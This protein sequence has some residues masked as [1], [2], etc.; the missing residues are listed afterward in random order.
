VRVQLG[1]SHDGIGQ[2]AAGWLAGLGAAGVEAVPVA[3][4]VAPEAAAVMR[5]V[6][7][8]LQPGRD[9]PSTPDVVLPL[10]DLAPPADLAGWR[11]ARDEVEVAVARWLDDR[12]RLARFGESVRPRFAIDFGDA[13]RPVTFLNHGSFGATPRAVLEAQRSWIE[14]LEAQPLAFY[15]AWPAR[16]RQVAARVAEALGADPQ[17]LVFVDNASTGVT[18]VL[19]SL[20]LQPGDVVVTT[21]HAYAAV[22]K[23]LDHA[24]ALSGARLVIA[25]VPFPIE[26]PEQVVA[27]VEAVLPERARIAVF[28]GITSITGLVLPTDALV[29]LCRARGIPVLV[30]AAHVPGHLPVDLGASQA[31]YWVG[32]LHKW[33]FACKGCAVL[34]VRRDRQD[35]VDPLVW[36]H[37]LDQGFTARFDFQGTRD[38]SP[39]LAADAA[40]AFRSE[41]GADRIRAHNVRLRR[42]AGAML[43][44]RLGVVAPAPGE[45]LG[46]LQTL[47]LPF[48]TEG[49]QDAADALNRRLWEEHRIEAMFMA[50]GGRVWLRIAA[51]IYNRLEDYERLAAALLALR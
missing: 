27:A 3:G 51:Q 36:S 49:C 40:L 24:V 14:A 44:E 31:D 1:T 18:A 5:E 16:I 43:C 28:D 42:E 48:A 32:N 10:P 6:G 7:I 37:G 38:P 26:S 39:W 30:D 4:E 22:R 8:D 11:R 19:R 25:R 29:A 45:M 12:G 41:L 33:L 13:E 20:R 35:E 17:D 21:D 34:H 2:L 47:P 9:G 15:R 23:A 50:F 46:A